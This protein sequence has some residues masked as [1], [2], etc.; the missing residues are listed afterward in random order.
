MNDS[1]TLARLDVPKNT[2]NLEASMCHMLCN[3]RS[4][5]FPVNVG[6]KLSMV[7]I[8]GDSICNT[9]IVVKMDKTLPIRSGYTCGNRLAPSDA[10]VVPYHTRYYRERGRPSML[11]KAQGQ[12][13]LT[14]DEEKALVSY[15]LL[16]SELRQPV[17]IKHIPTSWVAPLAR[18]Y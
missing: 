4:S 17:R 3:F 8:L 1:L 15:L 18:M 11:E 14:P 9:S 12:Q 10:N 7:L 2:R 13:Y 6:A 5:L 16:M